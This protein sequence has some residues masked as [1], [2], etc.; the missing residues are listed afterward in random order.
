MTA[1]GA[2]QIFE[3]ARVQMVVRRR[4][5]AVGLVPVIAYQRFLVECRSIRTQEG[6]LCAVQLTVMPNLASRL[7]V[8]KKPGELRIA[9]EAGGGHR[10]VH[11]VVSTANASLSERF[12]VFGPGALMDNPS[13]GG[14]EYELAGR[15][16]VIISRRLGQVG[17]RCSVATAQASLSRVLRV[18]G[19]A[20]V[21][22]HLDLRHVSR[23]GRAVVVTTMLAVTVFGVLLVHQ[24]VH[25]ERIGRG[26]GVVVVLA[27][28]GRIPL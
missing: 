23:V 3:E 27:L 6:F 9:P 25:E 20:L 13:S 4:G 10:R 28:V 19:N 21:Q 14:K 22:L 26:R 2:S 8:G 18:S 1:E 17:A 12:V 11:G 16:H 15:G 24:I 7:D 5:V